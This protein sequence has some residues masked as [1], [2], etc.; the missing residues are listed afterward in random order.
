MKKAAAKRAP[1][2]KARATK[3]ERGVARKVQK[4]ETASIRKSAKAARTPV[5][6]IDVVTKIAKMMAR[7]NG[8]SMEEMVEATKIAA[9]PMRAK[10][11]L[12]R[13]RLGYTTT[14][15]C[16][17]NGYRYHA[18]VPAA[19]AGLDGDNERKA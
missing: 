13:D 3:S 10:I 18:K 4:A 6:K 12:V 14:A 5:E 15:P 11:K 16:K 19:P 2:K 17:T 7:P 8:A 1:A 9:H